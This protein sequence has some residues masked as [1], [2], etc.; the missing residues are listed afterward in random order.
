MQTP[1]IIVNFKT[2][3]SAYG[4]R[5]IELAKLCEKVA[6]TTGSH[7]AV[8]VSAVDLCTVAEEVN[9]PVL[10]Q[11]ID[12]IEFGSH[13]GYIV[14]EDVKEAGAAGT[15]LNHSEH[16]LRMDVLEKS[17]KRAKENNLITIVCA[18]DAVEAKAVAVFEPDFIAIEPPELIGG[19]VS[20]SK[21]DPEIISDTVENVKFVNPNIPVLVGAGIK[22]TEDV[23]K[24]IELG[25]KGILVASGITKSEEPDRALLMMIKGME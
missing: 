22:T 16:R 5:A 4:K 20:V 1:I 15:L 17:I 19:D 12:D 3:D 11:H 6:K 9:I 2:Y 24:A 13:T 14:A 18:K 8:A 7:V 23:N 10:A 25:A 21:E